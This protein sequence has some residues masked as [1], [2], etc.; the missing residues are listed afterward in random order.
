[1]SYRH[2]RNLY[3]PEAQIILLFRECF[4]LEKIHGTSTHFSWR[5]GELAFH[6][7]GETHED[8]LAVFDRAKLAAA[9]AEKGHAEV[10]VYGEAYGGRQMGQAR[11]YGPA[12]RFVAFEV[13]VGDTWLAVPRAHAFVKAL[14]LEFVPYRRVSTDLGALDAERDAPSEQA[15]RCGVEGD[16]PREGV[17]L[18]PLVEL[19]DHD[20][21][22]IRAKHKRKE[23]RETE[24]Y[25]EVDPRQREALEDAEAIATE[26]VTPRRLEH[27]L[28]HLTVGGVSPGRKDTRKVI[29]AMVEDVLREGA[30]EVVDSEEAR[31]AIGT[32]TAQLFFAGLGPVPRKE[33]AS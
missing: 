28:A 8:F 19:L 21:L 26:W 29:A 3:E 2:I 1:V 12:L 6:P 13:K 14:G 5:A 22:P 16:Q 17:V 11:R 31:K 9:L 15:R 20:G 30:G 32:A 24:T 4:A 33:S 10:T 7:G 18:R 25:R 23:E 27:V